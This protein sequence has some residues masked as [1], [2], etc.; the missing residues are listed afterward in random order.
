V[1]R[2]A[3]THLLTQRGLLGKVRKGHFDAG[4]DQ[5]TKTTA[6][7]GLLTQ[8]VVVRPCADSLMIRFR[9]L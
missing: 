5:G 4:R 1:A 8:R 9:R 3:A 6:S 2:K 7:D